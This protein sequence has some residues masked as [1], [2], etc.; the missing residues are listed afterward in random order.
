MHLVVL[1]PLVMCKLQCRV[2]SEPLSAL[3]I[4]HTMCVLSFPAL[5]SVI[6]FEGFQFEG[7]RF[8]RLTSTCLGAMC[9][10]AEL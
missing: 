3:Q 1:W 10:A 4:Q 7:L 5:L 6:Y 8:C 2:R 9:H